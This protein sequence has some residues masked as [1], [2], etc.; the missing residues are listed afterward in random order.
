MKQTLEQK[1]EDLVARGVAERLEE[2]GHLDVHRTHLPF[3]PP[4]P[5]S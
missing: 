5:V 3:L 1:E 2:L 4:S